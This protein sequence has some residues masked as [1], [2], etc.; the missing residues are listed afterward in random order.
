MTRI[1]PLHI[2]KGRT[3]GRAISAENADKADGGQ[4]IKSFACG[5]RSCRQS[6]SFRIEAFE[7]RAAT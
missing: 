3:V 1:M 6:R 5:S 7:K 2:G 4:P